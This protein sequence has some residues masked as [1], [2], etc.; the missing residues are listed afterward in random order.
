MNWTVSLRTLPLNSK[1]IVV[2]CGGTGSFVA[3]GLCRILIG[4]EDA[5]ILLIDYDR[6]EEHN[7]MRQNFYEEDLGK[8][9]SQALAERLARQFRRR[10]AYSVYPFLHGMTEESSLGSGFRTRVSG[11][12]IGCVDNAAA[13]KELLD[14]LMH[15]P[16]GIWWLDSGNGFSS[17]QVLLGNAYRGTLE[18]SFVESTGEILRLPS[19]S[20]QLP[21]LL[22]PTTTLGADRRDCAEAVAAD[23]QSPFINQA[24][25][26]LVVTFVHKLLT[27]TLS[28]MGA[29]LDLT[30]GTLKVVPADPVTVARLVGM[31]VDILVN[32]QENKVKSRRRNNYG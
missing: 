32:K 5:P 6:V 30:A 23:E 26:N 4:K 18:R 27:G 16:A 11:I 3:E 17:G 25:A 12:F 7:L 19:P 14:E 29:Y 13:R 22:A 2:G 31:K 20:V 10:I 15:S 24:M 28:W 21:S 9:K 1:I 8:F